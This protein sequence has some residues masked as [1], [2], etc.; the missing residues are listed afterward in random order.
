MAHTLLLAAKNGETSVVQDLLARGAA[1]NVRDAAGRTP[2]LLA[3]H[4][5]HIETVRFLIEAGADVNLRC[6][7]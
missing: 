7:R 6:T 4:G 5:S 3:A 2:V 1:I